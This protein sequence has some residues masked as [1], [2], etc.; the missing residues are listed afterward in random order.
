MG[1]PWEPVAVR[2]SRWVADPWAG[3]AYSY[4]KVGADPSHRRSL[5]AAVDGTLFVVGEA[6]AVDAPGTM[7]GAWSEGERA[8]DELVGRCRS[9]VVVG[10]GLAGL[11]AARR[12]ASRGVEVV[13]LEAGD[14]V[15]GRARSAAWRE[16]HVLPGAMWMHGDI[17]HPLEPLVQAI[18]MPTEANVWGD[19]HV[20]MDS[21][22]T[23]VNGRRLQPHDIERLMGLA[24]QFE[25]AAESASQ[26]ADVALASVLEPWLAAQAADDRAVLG[27]WLLGEFEG[28]FAADARVGSTRWRREPY[29][30]AGDDVMLCGS[31][32]P[33]YAAL[34]D[35][36]DLR[37]NTAVRSVSRAGAGWSISGELQDL[38][39]AAS[40]GEPVC[41]EADGVIVT[42]SLAALD[43]IDFEPALPAPH[44]DALAKIGRGREGKVFA[45]FEEAFWSPLRSF[46][47]AAD[48]S[49]VQTFV[50]VSV[51]VGE[52]ALCGFA[53]HRHTES[54]EAADDHEV[55]AQ[56]ARSLE[57][58]WRWSQAQ[59]PH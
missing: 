40:T 3:M 39:A 42:A 44:L 30:A 21:V 34:C 35:G 31:M 19:D 33:V 4:L 5:G 20:P 13:V 28:V 14:V 49:W 29:V 53:P 11:A 8:A 45:V 15:G 1:R 54:L 50:D 27:A 25:Q 23:F 51:L 48:D 36:V 17:N 55:R 41:L 47:A 6:T 59:A 18:H 58:V 43:R 37:L 10:A 57:Q 46:V 16:G 9:V 24:E 32:D 12:L 38:G 2:P 52:P 26:K 22:P 7:H 56:I